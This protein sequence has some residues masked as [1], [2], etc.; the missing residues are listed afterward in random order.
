MYL[1]FISLVY[2]MKY[3]Y[4]EENIKTDNSTCPNKN[5]KIV[6]KKVQ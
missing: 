4:N 2:I 6:E 5:I 1:S 3:K